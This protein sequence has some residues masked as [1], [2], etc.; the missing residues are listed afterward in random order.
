MLINNIYNNLLGLTIYRKASWK[1]LIKF[2]SSCDYRRCLSERFLLIDIMYSDFIPYDWWKNKLK[3][4]SEGL[5]LLGLIE[6]VLP[7]VLCS[8]IIYI[9]IWWLTIDRKTSKESFLKVW[10][11]CGLWKASLAIISESLVYIPMKF[12]YYLVNNKFNQRIS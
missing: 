12:V 9:K 5:N 11:R 3:R 1:G 7:K 4:F 6:D 8:L 2:W 10:S